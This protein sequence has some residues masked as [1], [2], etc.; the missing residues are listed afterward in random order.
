MNYFKYQKCQETNL[1]CQINMSVSQTLL[2]S[3]IMHV[4]ESI[5]WKTLIFVF[6]HSYSKPVIKN[7]NCRKMP[8]KI[9]KLK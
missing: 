6:Y 5:S 9:F 8:K 7:V 2:L 3:I 4:L 1:P